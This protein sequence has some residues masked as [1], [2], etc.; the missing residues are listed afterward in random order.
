MLPELGY[1]TNTRGCWRPF[2]TDVFHYI[3]FTYIVSSFETTQ[4]GEWPKAMVGVPRSQGCH[5][6]IKRRVKCDQGQ[7]GC[8]NCRKYKANCPGYSKELKFISGKHHIR[9]RRNKAAESQVF[10]TA[11]NRSASDHRLASP[12]NKHS[13]EHDQSVVVT[14]V[15][16]P[17]PSPGQYIGNLVATVRSKISEPVIC[18]LEWVDLERLGRSPVLDSAI[19]SV[20]LY[21]VGKQASEPDV[22]ERSR[23]VYGKSLA[24]L[25]RSLKHPTAWKVSETLA[26]A[27]MLCLFE[28]CDCLEPRWF[29]QSQD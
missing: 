13:D 11:H 7:P 3:Y 27:M 17:T 16:T 6:C 14:L 8:Q 26:A 21:L 9:S 19:Y 25:Q 12:N 28:V 20:G 2:T 24:I 1:A 22:I 5:L 18:L 15:R 29:P 23:I 4:T 10:L